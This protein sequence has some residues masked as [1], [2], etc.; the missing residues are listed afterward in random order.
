MTSSREIRLLDGAHEE[1]RRLARS[2]QDAGL[3]A[4]V[5]KTIE[6]LAENPRHPSL[7]THKFKSLRG[8]DGQDVFEAYV[9][10]R[11]PGAYRV[12]FLYGPDRSEGEVRISVL[13]ILAI[14]PHP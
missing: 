6:F 8:P 9:Q 7:K 2:R 13:T 5:K 11:A 10:N 4:Q 3:Y 1:L 14:T 12:F